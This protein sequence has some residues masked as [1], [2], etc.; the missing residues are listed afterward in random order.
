MGLLAGVRQE[1]AGIE[2]LDR[3]TAAA[4]GKKIHL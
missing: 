2:L 3:H 4:V 1:P